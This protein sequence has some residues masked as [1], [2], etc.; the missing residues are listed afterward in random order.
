MTV[1]VCVRYGVCER[2][3][4]LARPCRCPAAA[5]ARC[6]AARS[7]RRTWWRAPLCARESRAVT[8]MLTFTFT[9]TLDLKRARELLG[10]RASR[11]HRCRRFTVRRR[12]EPP[13][14]LTRHGETE[15]GSRCAQW[16]SARSV[17]LARSCTNSSTRPSRPL[18]ALGASV[19]SVAEALVVAVTVRFCVQSGKRTPEFSSAGTGTRTLVSNRN[20]RTRTRQRC[21]IPSATISVNAMSATSRSPQYRATWR[22][23]QAVRV[24]VYAYEVE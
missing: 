16:N 6:R 3:R 7:S 5:P 24:R 10:L 17:S 19:H 22:A 9:L 21:R 20:G 13:S 15:K 14:H 23:G 18:A 11:L 4:P 12:S 8:F 1:G 2:A